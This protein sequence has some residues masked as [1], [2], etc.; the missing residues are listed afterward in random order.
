MKEDP[1]IGLKSRLKVVEEAIARSDSPSAEL[2]ELRDFYQREIVLLTR[3][4][5]KYE[6]PR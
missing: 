2:L 1:I 4:A 6:K 3:K 5:I